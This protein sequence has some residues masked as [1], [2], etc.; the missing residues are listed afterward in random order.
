MDYTEFS[1][2]FKS[3]LEPELAR[4]ADRLF[5]SFE[6]NFSNDIADMLELAVSKKRPHTVIEKLTAYCSH[7]RDMG[8]SINDPMFPKSA[9]YQKVRKFFREEIYNGTLGEKLVTAKAE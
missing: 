2:K 8:W 3:L 9:E 6:M 4:K 1:N 7:T 5:V